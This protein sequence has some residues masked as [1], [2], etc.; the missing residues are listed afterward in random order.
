MAA[1]VAAAMERRRVRTVVFIDRSRMLKMLVANNLPAFR[2]DI[3]TPLDRHAGMFRH[4]RLLEGMPKRKAGR[5]PL[6]SFGA[7]IS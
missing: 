6:E 2:D 5:N 1:A 3:N 4:R 7:G